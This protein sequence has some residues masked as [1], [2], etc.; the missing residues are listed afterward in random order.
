[1]KTRLILLTLAC[2][3]LAAPA[4]AQVIYVSSGGEAFVKVSPNASGDVVIASTYNFNPVTWIVGCAFCNCT[5]LTSVAIPSGVTR[6]GSP[7]PVFS[8]C[9][10]LTNISVD[11]ANTTYSSLGGVVFNKA[12]TTLITFPPARSSY[13]IPNSVTSIGASAFVNCTALTSVTIA[14]SVVGIGD[15]AFSGCTSLTNVT[16][17]NGVTGIGQQAFSGCTNLTSV[18]IGNSV[19]S[20][21]TTPYS[22]AFDGCTSLTNFSVDAA[23]PAYSSLNGVLFNKAQTTLMLF[24]PGRGGSYVIPAS[25]TNIGVRAFAGCTRLTNV[26]MGNGVT[27][28]GSAAFSGCTNLTGATIPNSVTIIPDR[29]FENCT[30]LTSVTI[31]NGVISIGGAAFNGCTG[32]TSVTIPDSVTQIG[33]GLYAG[34]GSSAFAYCTSLTNVIIGHSVTN[35]GS[36][37]FSACSNLTRLT[38]P[39]SVINLGYAAFYNASRLTNFTFLGNAPRLIFDM[40]GGYAQF[41]SVGAGAK[42]YYYCGTTGWGTSYGTLPTV[43]LCPPQIA[44][45]SVGVKPGGFGFTL[46]RLTNQTIVVEASTNL[47]NWQPIWT[48]SLPGA[49]AEFVDP[50]WLQQPRRFYRARSN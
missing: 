11:A 39:A 21:G 37:A 9:R 38:I 43:M 15:G 45:G 1:M 35:I 42:A 17:P 27:S 4:T 14:N 46:T 8:G 31:P 32:L 29:A 28:F 48:N 20:M 50:E 10:S 34:G 41:D 36:G 23:H 33:T 47:V 16:I 5:N 19:T 30:S 12:Q 18:T 3:L 2:L 7:S 13:V 25:V 6:L 44:P 26:T 24:P 22:G 40:D 49:S